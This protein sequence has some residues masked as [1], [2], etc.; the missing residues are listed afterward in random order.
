MAQG[1]G[2]QETRRQA[3]EQ[4]LPQVE[5]FGLMVVND[6]SGSKGATHS[7]GRPEGMAAQDSR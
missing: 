4:C 2:N 7:L 3:L 5:Q 1:A 6:L